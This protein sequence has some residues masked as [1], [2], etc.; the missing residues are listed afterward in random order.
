M[1]P[2]LLLITVRFFTPLRW[3]AAIRFSGFPHRPNPPDMITAPSCMSRMA[4]SALP[5]T[6][7][8]HPSRR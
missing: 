3:I 6:L 1:V 5:T 7:F 8:M 2:Q 4:S